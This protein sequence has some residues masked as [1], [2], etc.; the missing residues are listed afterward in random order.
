M[1]NFTRLKIATAF[2]VV[3]CFCMTVHT[4]Q[5]ATKP[6]SNATAEVAFLKSVSARYTFAKIKKLLPRNTKF[7]APKWDQLYGNRITF[8][9]KVSGWLWFI[10]ERKM[11]QKSLDEEKFYSTSWINHVELVMDSGTFPSDKD[12]QLRIKAVQKILGKPKEYEYVK[13]DSDAVGDAW[14]LPGW[15]ASWIISGDRPVDC[16][17]HYGINGKKAT[18]L[19]LGI[20]GWQGAG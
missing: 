13:A 9:G 3:S 8:R 16:F 1:N 15:R 2:T 6:G 10:S 20:G 19:S 18:I 11:K 5:A 14:M 4:S 12:T 7:S 17:N